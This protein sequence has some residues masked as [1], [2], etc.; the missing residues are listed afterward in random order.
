M[1]SSKTGQQ[2][3][4]AGT[5]FSIRSLIGSV[6]GA[7]EKILRTTVLNVDCGMMFPANASRTKPVRT[8]VRPVTGSTVPRVTRRE[9]AGLNIWPK[10]TV[11]PNGSSCRGR[12]GLQILLAGGGGDP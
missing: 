10:L 11:R 2:D 1:R 7:W 8:A 12:A 6:I 9:V 3:E 5:L 4:I